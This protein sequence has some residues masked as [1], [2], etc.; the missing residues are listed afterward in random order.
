[1]AACEC[2][3]RAPDRAQ[4]ALR[5][6]ARRVVDELGRFVRD[7]KVH[8]VLQLQTRVP[9]SSMDGRRLHVPWDAASNEIGVDFA[10]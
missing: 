1:M 9:Y 4:G 6:T 8:V 10:T 3:P 7:A 5:S 2:G